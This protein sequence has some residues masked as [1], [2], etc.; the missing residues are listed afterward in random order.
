MTD[1]EPLTG[2]VGRGNLG[3]IL[4]VQQGEL[5]GHNPNDAP[6]CT[7]VLTDFGYFPLNI[8]ST[9]ISEVGDG[10]LPSSPELPH[11]NLLAQR[12]IHS[13]VTGAH[14]E[15]AGLNF[16]TVGRRIPVGQ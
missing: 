10:P 13:G 3:Q 12:C 14:H 1:D 6:R 8:L 15:F 2:I 9:Q 11:G 16:P 7:T 4:L 5:Q